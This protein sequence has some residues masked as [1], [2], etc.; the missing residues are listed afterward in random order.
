MVQNLKKKILSKAQLAGV[1]SWKIR[2]VTCSNF[3]LKS[4]YHIF[5]SDQNV[6]SFIMYTRLKGWEQNYF[7][8]KERHTFDVLQKHGIRYV[9][10]HKSSHVRPKIGVCVFDTYTQDGIKTIFNVQLSKKHYVRKKKF[11]R[12][13]W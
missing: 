13:R 5:W 7:K 9:H 11:V 1:N 4:A 8:I 2:N 6:S 3:N 12:Q 10:G